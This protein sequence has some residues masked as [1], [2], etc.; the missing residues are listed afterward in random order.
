MDEHRQNG[1]AR[2]PNTFSLMVEEDENYGTTAIPINIPTSAPR[3]GL[4]AINAA[5][6]HEIQPSLK[7]AIQTASLICMQEQS[8]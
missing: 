4:D 3:D 1:A 7:V 2:L 8:S 5:E 6:L